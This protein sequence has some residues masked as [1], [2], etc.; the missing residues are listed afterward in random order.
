MGDQPQ[1]IKTACSNCNK[2]IFVTYNTK[3]C[4]NC[5][6]AFNENEVHNLFHAQETYIANSKMYR[7]GKRLEKFGNGMGNLA[8]LF[9]AIGCFLMLVP[10]V[11]ICV[12]IIWALL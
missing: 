5:G 4:P 7:S 6:A 9:N 12:I 11:V 3:Q 2:K 8:D 10:I 1:A